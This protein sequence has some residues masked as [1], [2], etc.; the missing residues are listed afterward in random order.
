MA[1]RASPL[2]EITSA[3]RAS[4]AGGGGEVASDERSESRHLNTTRYLNRFFRRPAASRKRSGPISPY[5]H[6][7]PARLRRR[8][9][10]RRA[11]SSPAMTT[12][13]EHGDHPI[14]GTHGSRRP[15]SATK[16]PRHKSPVDRCRGARLG[17]LS[18]ADGGKTVSLRGAAR[19]ANGADAGRRIF[20]RSKRFA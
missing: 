13:W 2:H 7:C 6:A 15:R 17:R 9:L 10:W 20:H 12:E 18:S 1:G 11:W 19:F 4:A 3:R 14:A 16:I 8:S 5:A